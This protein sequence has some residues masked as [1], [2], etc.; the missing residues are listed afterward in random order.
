MSFP[1]GLQQRELLPHYRTLLSDEQVLNSSL[2]LWEADFNSSKPEEQLL[3]GNITLSNRTA[4]N[5][6]EQMMLRIVGGA[7]ERLGGSPWQVCPQV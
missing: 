2:E 7:L 3:T 6:T 4:G 1:C 5:R